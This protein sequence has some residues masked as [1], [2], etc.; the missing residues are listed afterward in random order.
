MVEF[1]TKYFGKVIVDISDGHGNT[2]FKYNNREIN[3][4]LVI[5]NFMR[6]S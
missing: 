5:I 4:F 1:E 6:I 3:I 2:D